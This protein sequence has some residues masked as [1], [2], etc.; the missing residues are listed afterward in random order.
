M[1]DDLPRNT[2]VRKIDGGLFLIKSKVMELHSMEM[3]PCYLG[4]LYY[5]TLDY[6][7]SKCYTNQIDSIV[8]KP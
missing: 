6:F 5:S 1:Y 3:I 2:L 8:E 4:H 7:T